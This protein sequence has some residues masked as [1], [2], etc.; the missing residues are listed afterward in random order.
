MTKHNGH[1]NTTKGAQCKTPG[2]GCT[3]NADTGYCF[4]CE[5]AWAQFGRDVANWVALRDAAIKLGWARP[6]Q[7]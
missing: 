6:E 3:A 4:A 1:Q 2:C 5:I 7:K